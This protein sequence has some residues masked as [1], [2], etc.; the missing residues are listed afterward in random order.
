MKFDKGTIVSLIGWF[1]WSILM[2]V[3]AI[4]I[5]VG[6]L[7]PPLNYIAKPVVCPTGQFNYNQNVSNPYPG[8][9]YVTA[10]WVCTDS[11]TGA[12]TTFNAI[13]MSVYTGPFYGL[14]LFLG[15]LP[16]WYQYTLSSQRKKAA[17]AEWQR[18][19]NAEFGRKSKRT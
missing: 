5:G 11:Q 13:R 18:K 10:A 6:A 16:F 1:A 17:D 14:L 8:A 19:W 4:S 7:F 2:G 9:T 15:V 3:T 12:Q